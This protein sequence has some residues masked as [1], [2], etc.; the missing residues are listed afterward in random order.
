MNKANGMYK[1]SSVE[2][3]KE[4]I[5]SAIEKKFSYFTSEN[6]RNYLKT[7]SQFHQYSFNNTLLIALQKPDATLVASYTAWQQKF[8]RQ[9]RKGEKGITIIAPVPVK[10]KKE[11]QDI[12]SQPQYSQTS[13]AG[14]AKAEPE[15]KL[16]LYFKA[17]TVFDISSTDGD[18][19][20]T[21][22]VKELTGSAKGYDAFMQA[23]TAISPVPVR[24]DEVEGGAKGYYHHVIKEIVV[25]KDM[26]QRQ[27]MK[28]A[29][30][31]LSH[32]LLHDRDHM[33]QEGIQK[34]R[35]LIE[36]EAESVAFCVCSY[37]GLDEENGEGSS[38]GDYSF[39]Y[40]AGW[41]QS[42]DMTELRASME[43]IRK[44]AGMI[45]DGIETEMTK[46]LGLQQEVSPEQPPEQI[47]DIGE[48]GEARPSVLE[49]LKKEKQAAEKNSS[50]KEKTAMIAD[51]SKSRQTGREMVL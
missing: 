7:M 29:A 33:K 22:D 18:P 37:F 19:L 40:I 15:E 8:H 28:T 9:V 46:Q 11:L 31:E 23:L 32:A 10:E 44:T 49:A 3:I 2:E 43:T 38:V 6:Y 51:R 34:S 17:V 16:H 27:T 48:K 20:P 14:Q 50:G 36:Q 39:P 25:Q 4:S 41:A 21:L 1:S 12:R 24:F 5:N 13:Q 42:A 47:Q 26:S 45:I 35:Q 30:H